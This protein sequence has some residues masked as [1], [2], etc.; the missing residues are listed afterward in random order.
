MTALMREQSG[1][2][3]S[4][5]AQGTATILSQFKNI[6]G[7]FDP[8][9]PRFKDRIMSMNR[10]LTA[11]ANDFQRA[12]NF[13]TLS[14]INP[15]ASYLDILGM[16]ERGI[17]QK[18]FLGETIKGYQKRFG[19][20]DLTTLA[21]K[22]RFNLSV[23]QA[24][25]LM[26]RFNEDPS[27]FDAITT[28]EGLRDQLSTKDLKGLA[29][30][31]TSHHLQTKAEIEEAFVKGVTDGLILAGEKVA[32]QIAKQLAESGVPFADAAGKQLLTYFEPKSGHGAPG[33]GSQ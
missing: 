10:G 22:E 6:G 2:L 30:R 8:S 24:K 18:G 5:D 29:G 23:D 27:I 11:P 28:D 20:G 7:S 25:T 31:R 1:T 32:H 14:G 26:S 17:S 19:G 4:I 33:G 21:V 16:Q 12:M 15:N 13:S 9:D 3:E